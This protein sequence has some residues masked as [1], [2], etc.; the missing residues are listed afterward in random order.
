MTTAFVAVLAGFTVLQNFAVDFGG[1]TVVDISALFDGYRTGMIADE[2]RRIALANAASTMTLA[3]ELSANLEVNTLV[4]HLTTML[5]VAVGPSGARKRI[6]ELQDSC[7][8][9]ADLF[10][11]ALAAEMIQLNGEFVRTNKME[12]YS[13][14]GAGVEKTPSPPPSASGPREK[15]ST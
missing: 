10:K 7:G 3:N 15:P 5:A 11:R 14:K 6:K 2:S 12:W 8:K 13:M 4:N 9:D 1:E